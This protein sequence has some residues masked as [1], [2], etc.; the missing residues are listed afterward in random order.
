M[1]VGTHRIRQGVYP[2]SLLA[3]P[4]SLAAPLESWGT[5]LSRKQCHTHRLRARAGCT[6][7]VQSPSAVPDSRPLPSPHH[8]PQV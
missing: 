4:A 6:V 8:T 5:G 1:I 3:D 2:S 7:Q